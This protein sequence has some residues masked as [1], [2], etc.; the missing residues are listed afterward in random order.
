MSDEKKRQRNE[1]EYR[2]NRAQQLGENLRLGTLEPNV[3]MFR[4]YYQD[5][6]PRQVGDYEDIMS[7]YKNFAETG[8]FSPQDTSN[9]RARAIA[10]TRAV[11]ANAQRELGRSR[12]LQGDYSPGYATAQARLS[13]DLSSGLSD[14]NTNAEAA[15]AQMVQQGKLAGLSGA[16]GLYGTTPGQAATFGNQLLSSTGQLISGIGNEQNLALG[17]IDSYQRAAGLPGKWEGT[18]GR[19]GN[20]AGAV[21]PWLEP[22]TSSVLPSR[23]LPGS[24]DINSGLYRP[25]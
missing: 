9:I 6:V 1:I 17:L 19:I 11:Y 4:G 15:I 16:T 13:R 3:D 23:R 20:V 22:T 7:G 21:Y 14:A 24:E 12:A 2:G 18:V 8:G 25:L 10:P 5:A